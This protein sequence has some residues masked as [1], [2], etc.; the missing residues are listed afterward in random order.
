MSQSETVFA[1][2]EDLYGISVEELQA[3]L[4][5]LHDE[6]RRIEAELEKKRKDLGDA[7]KLF[8]G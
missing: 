4:K 3:R 2:G 8:G 7:Q 6:T 1:I 5:I